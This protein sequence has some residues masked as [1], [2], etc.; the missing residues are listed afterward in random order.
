M[1]YRDDG[2]L[3]ITVCSGK[4]TAGVT[5]LFV[6]VI[7]E[8]ELRPQFHGPFAGR[9]QGTEASQ[10]VVALVEDQDGGFDTGF[11]IRRTEAEFTIRMV[12]HDLDIESDQVDVW[13]VGTDGIVGGI[14]IAHRVVGTNLGQDGMA[15]RWFGLL[16]GT[17]MLLQLACAGRGCEHD[18]EGVAFWVERIAGRLELP[19]YPDGKLP[20]AQIDIL[21]VGKRLI[22]LLLDQFVSMDEG[23]FAYFASIFDDTAGDLMNVYCF[24]GFHVAP[25]VPLGIVCLLSLR[26]IGGCFFSRS[27]SISLSMVI[28]D[29]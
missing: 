22:D 19:L 28:F 23:T 12:A 13:I 5:G 7:G 14:T 17:Q 29:K 6:G 11:S 25:V 27:L 4:V 21:S 10:E 24:Q 18:V 1:R 16:V 8:L 26:K 9:E 15:A 3:W 20:E 2:I